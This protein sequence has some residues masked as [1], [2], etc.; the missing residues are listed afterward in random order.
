[1]SEN[2]KVLS[3]KAWDRKVQELVLAYSMMLGD[4][5]PLGSDLNKM[6]HGKLAKQGFSVDPADLARAKDGVVFDTIETIFNFA[7]SCDHDPKNLTLAKTLA[8]EGFPSGVSY[9]EWSSHRPL[10][11]FVELRRSMIKA[12]V[13][14][15]TDRELVKLYLSLGSDLTHEVQASTLGAHIADALNFDLKI[16]AAKSGE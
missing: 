10:R 3:V 14:Q 2:D 7:R 5:I 1:M 13:V 8:N 11:K 6:A 4:E 9:P 16:L 15:D 12:G